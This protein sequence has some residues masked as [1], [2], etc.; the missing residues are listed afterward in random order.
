MYLYLNLRIFI[1][2]AFV[3]VFV[4]VLV[5]LLYYMYDVFEEQIVVWWPEM[6]NKSVN[7]VRH[8]VN[9]DMH[10]IL[11]FFIFFCIFFAFDFV[12]IVWHSFDIGTFQIL[13]WR[14]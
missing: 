4:F 9:N 5:F 6:V 12:N 11:I 2:F 8:P 7:I 1:G 10:H 3:F 13:E 14:L